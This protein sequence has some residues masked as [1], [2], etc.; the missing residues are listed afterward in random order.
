MVAPQ[1]NEARLVELATAGRFDAF[2]SLYTRHLD[3]I[4]RYTYYRTGNTQDAEDLTEQVFIKAWEGM[5]GYRAA[6]CA[7]AGWLYRIAHNLMVDYYRKQKSSGK[8][9]ELDE[10]AWTTAPLESTLDTVIK[11]E[12]TNR[13]AAAI[14]SLPDDYQQ[15][16]SL[17]FI[18]GL[19]HAEIAGIMDKSEN[20]CRALQHR[21]LAALNRLLS[22]QEERG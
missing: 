19:G 5:P 13:L 21:A 8:S 12:E 10:A 11:A 22:T 14:A 15:I 2:A 20:A 6:G 18:E 16:I 17:R 3:A 7:F 9:I 4:Y 1:D